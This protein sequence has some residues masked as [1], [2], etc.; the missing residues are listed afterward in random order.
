MKTTEEILDWLNDRID[1]YARRIK[2]K[3]GISEDRKL[4]ERLHDELSELRDY[5]VNC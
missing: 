1:V 5:I 2:S 4:S 3:R